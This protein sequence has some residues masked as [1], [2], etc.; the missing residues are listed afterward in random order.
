VS[1]FVERGMLR[2]LHELRWR[3]DREK[4]QRQTSERRDG[5]MFEQRIGEPSVG[6]CVAG[7]DERVAFAVPCVAWLRAVAGVGGS[8]GH[9][10]RDRETPLER[11]RD[12]GPTPH[13]VVGAASRCPT[14]GRAGGRPEVPAL[15][16]VPLVPPVPAVPGGF[17]R[18]PQEGNAATVATTGAA[19]RVA[20][21]WYFN[22]WIELM[23]HACKSGARA[24][25]RVA[26]DALGRSAGGPCGR[27]RS[28]PV[29]TREHQRDRACRTGAG[30]RIRFGGGF[31][32]S[33]TSACS[34]T[35]G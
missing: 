16:V 11:R 15:V 33:W 21:S 17:S 26:W 24:R 18:P 19:A 32:R 20:R 23:T 35:E 10:R 9:R 28:P 25:P 5:C 13:V 14:R 34:R 3:P 6:E 12:A 22:R 7:V 30:G 4:L 29:R 27:H 31:A 2:C 1:R 8:V